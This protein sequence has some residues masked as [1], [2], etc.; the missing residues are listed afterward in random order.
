M[1]KNHYFT[2]RRIMVLIKNGDVNLLE[3]TVQCLKC[4]TK[5]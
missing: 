5:S 4:G 3:P 2:M 1:I